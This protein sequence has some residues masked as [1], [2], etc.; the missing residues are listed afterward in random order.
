MPRLATALI[1]ST[2]LAGPAAAETF[3][4]WQVS[5]DTARHCLA[6]GLADNPDARGYLTIRRQPGDT[7][8]Q[9]SFWLADPDGAV[10]G[11]SYVLHAG[12]KPLA[13]LHQPVSFGEP[14][15]EGGLIQASLPLNAVADLTDALRRRQSL[16]LQAADG[17][18]AVN[19]SLEGAMA[20]WLFMEDRL[21]QSPAPTGGSS[22]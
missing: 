10:T 20:A 18:V 1:L 5:C 15:E 3:K 4:D 11:R 9:I 6:T 22:T 21:S 7:A 8:A 19:V 13:G 16:Q 12:G 14:E 2:L 17:S